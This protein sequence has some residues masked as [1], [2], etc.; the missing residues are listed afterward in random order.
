MKLKYHSSTQNGEKSYKQNS[1]L[2]KNL[3]QY[4]ILVKLMPSK[5]LNKFT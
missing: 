4:N 2:Q 3:T 1:Y 5:Q